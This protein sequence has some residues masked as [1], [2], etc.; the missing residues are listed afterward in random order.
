MLPKPTCTE[1]ESSGTESNESM[2][3]PA[4]RGRA[5]KDSS[6]E[7]LSICRAT[8]YR[9]VP[10][11]IRSGVGASS[12]A[13]SNSSTIRPAAGLPLPSAV[14][15]GVCSPPLWSSPFIVASSAP[16]SFSTEE[17]LIGS[18]FHQPSLTLVDAPQAVESWNL[19]LLQ[20]H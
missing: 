3:L 9:L 15:V 16:L 11:P 14:L 17:E 8:L 1:G 2:G 5:S 7:G 13:S 19:E 10:L 18:W 12:L 6:S 20:A 4:L